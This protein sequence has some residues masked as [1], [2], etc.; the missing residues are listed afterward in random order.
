MH[1]L[2]HL[3]ISQYQ[4][5]D[6]QASITLPIRDIHARGL[7]IVHGG[8]LASLIDTVTGMAASTVCPED[9]LTL[10]IEL[11]ANYVR[12]V[13]VGETIV[14]TATVEHRGR[15]TVVASSRITNADDQPVAIGSAT[16]LYV[17]ATP[18]S[19]GIPGNPGGPPLPKQDS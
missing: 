6:G 9:H 2:K 15:T 16:M 4:A 7:D 5:R 12:R 18:G 10:T 14:A 17:P 1:F 13:N 8:V 3:Q 11:K 19:P